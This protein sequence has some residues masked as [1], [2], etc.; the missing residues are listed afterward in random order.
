MAIALRSAVN[1]H[2]ETDSMI[3]ALLISLFFTAL[4]G[5][6]LFALEGSGP[7]ANTFV[8][9]WPGGL[10]E[11]IH[12]LSADISMAL[13]ILH[14]LGVMYT[15]YLYRENLSKSMITGKKNGQQRE[16]E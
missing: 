1:V 16:L 6:A 7:F 11:D 9:S 12:E 10:L 13:V 5:M 3:V 2:G 15:S 14:V 8:M 4:S